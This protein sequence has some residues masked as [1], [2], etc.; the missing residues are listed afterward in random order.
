MAGPLPPRPWLRAMASTAAPLAP[1]LAV[2]WYR[3]L[4]YAEE[5][6]HY[7]NRRCAALHT[8]NPALSLK[9]GVSL[10][11]L[12]VAVCEGAVH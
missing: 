12:R 6:F 1:P 10:G 3:A 2:E 11:P 4:L 7:D 5:N 8:T 9:V